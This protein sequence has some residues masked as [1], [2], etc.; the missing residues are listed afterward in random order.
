MADLDNPSDPRESPIKL[1][2]ATDALV[3]KLPG[4]WPTLSWAPFNGG[5]AEASCIFNH[6]VTRA[7]EIRMPEIFHQLIERES[8]PED[9]VG[10]LTG[11]EVRNYRE[12]YISD[13]RLWVH[14]LATVGIENARAPGDPADN[15]EDWKD[16][17]T[18]EQ[19]NE[20]DSAPSFGTVNLIVACNALPELSGRA[21]ATHIAS[22]AKASAFFD[23]EIKSAKSGRP[24]PGTGTDCIVVAASG[25][26]EENYCG[27][28]TRLGEFIGQAVYECTHA[29]LKHWLARKD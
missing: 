28:H 20:G 11:A 2:L 24:S 23:L 18:V 13:G 21:E 15:P 22:L 25:E 19:S 9:S 16:E 3:V 12:S 5:A 29:A 6:Q 8:L 7:R 27:M 14:A 17:T 10:L 4:Q 26:V 1:K